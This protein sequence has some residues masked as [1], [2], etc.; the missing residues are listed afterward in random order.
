[1]RTFL[2]KTLI[3]S[4]LVLTGLTAAAQYPPRPENRRY[5]E[6]DRRVDEFLDRLRVDLDRA[7]ENAFPF[8]G[9]HWRIARANQALNDFQ[10]DWNSGNYDRRDLN[11]LIASVQRVADQNR[12]PGHYRDILLQDLDRMR[13]FQAR[14]DP[15]RP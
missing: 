1:M 10:S 8:S 15:W 2:G 14:L 9:D 4:G 12:L 11:R 13:N 6:R 5:E 7:D 3:G